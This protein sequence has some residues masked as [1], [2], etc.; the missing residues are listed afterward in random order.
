MRRHRLMGM[1]ETTTKNTIKYI[2][3]GILEHK[4][5]LKNM[6]IIH[7]NFNGILDLTDSIGDADWFFIYLACLVENPKKIME[8]GTWIGL[9][10]YAM[11][12]ASNALIYTCDQGPDNFFIAP[13]KKSCVDR[14]IRHPNTHSSAFT[15]KIDDGF[16][17]IFNDASLTDNDAKNLFEKC[18]DKFTFVTH[19]YY[20]LTK[21]NRVVFCKGRYAI[22]RMM[23]YAWNNN[24][25]TKLFTPAKN[26]YSTEGYWHSTGLWKISIN[27]CCAMLKI[28]REDA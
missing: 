26:W 3:D 16:D 11:A 8:I 7:E 28:E 19:D 24:Y 14:I 6:P 9:S 13:D 12:L 4:A 5:K 27:T 20:K 1:S 17:F 18:E 15:K 21:Y 25:K 10:T 2:E 22:E 23:K